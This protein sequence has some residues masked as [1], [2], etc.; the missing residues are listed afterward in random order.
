MDGGYDKFVRGD[1]P[2]GPEIEPLPTDD[3][4]SIGQEKYAR[5]EGSE[6]IYKDETRNTADDNEASARA[7]ATSICEPDG[8]TE[9]SQGI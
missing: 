3:E 7:E 5:R 1:L 2:V 6:S 9:E 4:V 8:E